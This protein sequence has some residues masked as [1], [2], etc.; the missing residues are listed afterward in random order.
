METL[1]SL[2]MF[3]D[4]I[5]YFAISFFKSYLKLSMSSEAFSELA[6]KI[7]KFAIFHKTMRD[8]FVKA[9]VFFRISL[10]KLESCNWAKFY[11]RFSY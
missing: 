9:R 3:D 8:N 1:N 7:T 10:N 4:P 6:T 11:G 2:F 5:L